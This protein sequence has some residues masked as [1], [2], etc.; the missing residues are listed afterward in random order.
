MSDEGRVKEKTYASEAVPKDQ[1]MKTASLFGAMSGFVFMTTTLQAG[2]TLGLSADFLTVLKAILVGSIF[3]GV[4]VCI[5]AATAAKTGL[6]FAQ[7]AA[8]AYGKVGA[9]FIGFLLAFS[10]IG[11]AAVDAGLMASALKT[12]LP[13]VPHLVL[14]IVSVVLFIVTAI[15]GMKAMSKLGSLCI[16]IIGLF[17]IVSLVIGLHSLGGMNGL[18][19]YMPLPTNELKFSALVGLVIGSWIGCA[20]SLLPDFM[21]FAKNEKVAVTMGAIFMFV[22]NPLLLI[23]GAVGAIATKS[24]DISFILASQGLMIPGL[25][26]GIFGNWGPAQGN[27]YST[28]LTWDNIF[29]LGHKNMTLVCGAIALVFVS[30]DFFSYFGNFIIFLSNCV[31]AIIAVFIVDSLMTYK[32][33]YP[34]VAEM[35]SA[36]DWRG[37]LA[38][39]GGVGLAFAGLPGIPQIWGVLG[40]AALR[41]VLNLL[42]NDSPYKA[43]SQKNIQ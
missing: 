34:A 12:I 16:P 20:C 26:I 33:G 27:L 38:T 4:L 1:R 43:Y 23:I 5:M 11:W 2:A 24:G 21:R 18:M 37:I 8:Y 36:V 42:G 29:K 19:E 22:L 31:P 32:K 15:V 17:G 40:A 35:K 30:L 3:L 6:T 25:L 14:S 7:I 10:L 41:A 13:G 28:T 9:K 39:V